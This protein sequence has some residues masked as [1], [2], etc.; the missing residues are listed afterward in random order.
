[1]SIVLNLYRLQ[2]VD[3]RLDQ[4]STRLAAIQSILENDAELKAA[5][6]RHEK[7]QADLH[8][9]ERALKNSE[10]EVASQRIKIEQAESSLYSGRIQN[11]KELQDLQND[12][13]ALKRH[14]ARLEDVELEAMLALDSARELFET[15]QKEMN[16]TQGRVITQNASLHA[17][18]NSLQ[19]EAERFH[20]QRLAVLPA[21]DSAVLSQ[22]DDLRQQRRGLAVSSISDNACDSCGAMLTPG[23][24]QSVRFSPKIV[25][26]PSCGRILYAS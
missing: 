19:K 13:A 4:I 2:Q 24:A 23:L 14:L 16:A 18:Q 7:A 15:T 11:P 3:S 1:M 5:R 17:E 10:A 8:A 9:A 12:A 26:C 21:I 20:A 22:Y 25:N 6:E